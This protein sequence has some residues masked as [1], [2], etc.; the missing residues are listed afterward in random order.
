MLNSKRNTTK[1]NTTA[2]VIRQF[3]P[4]SQEDVETRKAPTVVVQNARRHLST[5]QSAMFF[6]ASRLPTTVE[7]HVQ[8]VDIITNHDTSNRTS[9]PISRILDRFKNMHINNIQSDNNTHTTIHKRPLSTTYLPHARIESRHIP[10]S[11]GQTGS[12]SRNARRCLTTGQLNFPNTTDRLPTPSQQHFHTTDGAT[13]PVSII[14]DRFRNMCMIDSH[15]GEE[16]DIVRQPPL[17]A[18]N[19]AYLCLDVKDCVVRP[20]IIGFPNIS[21]EHAIIQQPLLTTLNHIYLCLDVK[22]CA[23]RLK[24]IGLPN[25]SQE[26]RPPSDLPTEHSC[27]RTIFLIK[28]L[29]VPFGIP[30]DPKLF[31]KD[32][33]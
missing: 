13:M 6:E 15:T 24:I 29:Y 17:K 32:G 11:D 31:F 7:H 14:F 4:H 10:M 28:N 26:N 9:V 23:V 25:S 19:H 8:T 3:T 22:D 27:G 30:F 18:L 21:D 20:E 1:T 12:V 5:S 33:I 16:H 2:D